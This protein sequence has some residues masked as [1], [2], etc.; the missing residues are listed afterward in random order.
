LF[1]CRHI[2]RMAEPAKKKRKAIMI[3]ED[4]HER[5]KVRAAQERCFINEWVVA[6]LGESLNSKVKGVK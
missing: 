6:A 2:Q 1:V 3:D 4:F 5:L